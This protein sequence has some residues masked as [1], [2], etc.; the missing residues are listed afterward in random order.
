MR[1]LV[2]TRFG[3]P[4]VLEL[5]D[6]PDPAPG[7]GE[8]LVA[9]AAAGVNYIDVYQRRG[10]YP[11]EPPFVAGSE[12]AGTVVAV[13]DDVA[14]PAVGDRVA[15]LMV[16]G[17][18]Y[19]ER[20]VVPAERCVPVPDDIDDETAA[21]VMLQGITAEYL[22]HATHRVQAGDHVLVH[23][24]A[25]GVGQL[26]TRACVALGATVIGTVST[27]EKAAVARAAGARHTVDYIRE[28]VAETVARLTD[29]R[30]VRVAYDGVGAPTQQASLDS[31]GRRGTYVVFGQAGGAPA[32]VEA[33]TLSARGSLFFTRPT[34]VD[35]VVEREELL[36][37]AG[38][39]FGWL[40]DG[41]LSVAI[42]ARYPLA[43][44]ARA[45]ADL[46]GR[47]TV[48]KLLVIP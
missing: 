40:R 27:A 44:A 25:G 21:A 41:T 22:T 13:G 33:K 42:S 10:V 39:V 6:L 5:R 35:H 47:R 8:V 38:R 20:V 43:D 1:A 48:G 37:R 4:D 23:A 46:E 15:W 12:G 16:P 34:V 31:L 11:L 18:G 14:S 7:R 30:G 2:V 9:V 28:D 45:Q 24:A 17:A 19:A 32:P 3:E 29:G 26:L 36:D